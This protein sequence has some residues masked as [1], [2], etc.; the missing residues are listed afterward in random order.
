VAALEEENAVLKA[1]V[2]ELP[3]VVAQERKAAAEEAVAGFRSSAEH[4]AIREEEY[5]RGFDAGY[6]KHFL[7]LFEK[8]WINVEKYYADMERESAAQQEQGQTTGPSAEVIEQVVGDV[9]EPEVVIIKETRAE[10][11]TPERLPVEVAPEGVDPT[12]LKANGDPLT[13][14]LTP[15]SGPVLERD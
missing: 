14:G 3:V 10:E 6:E 4:S 13:L 9:P 5:H 8:D 15:T 11:R 2:A 7:T 1:K 12:L